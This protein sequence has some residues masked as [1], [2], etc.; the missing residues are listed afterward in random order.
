VGNIKEV[1]INIIIIIFEEILLLLLFLTKRSYYYYV[2]IWSQPLPS[3][4]GVFCHFRRIFNQSQL[5]TYAICAKKLSPKFQGPTVIL[6][7]F[8]CYM[9]YVRDVLI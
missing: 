9:L 8:E 3:I 4:L 2:I 6:Y 5:Y 1:I 7:I